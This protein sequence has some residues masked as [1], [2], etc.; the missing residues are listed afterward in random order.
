MAFS[1]DI[2]ELGS[3]ICTVKVPSRNKYDQLGMKEVNNSEH[4]KN[5]KILE[6]LLKIT[7]DLLV[8]KGRK[9]I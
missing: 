2:L 7:G 8:I 6:K 3:E 5:R 1:L 9:T 4:I